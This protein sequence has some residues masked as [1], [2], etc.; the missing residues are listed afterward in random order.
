L[1]FSDYVART[2]NLAYLREAKARQRSAIR[3]S[4]IRPSRADPS[5]R[6]ISPTPPTNSNTTATTTATT[7]DTTTTTESNTEDDNKVHSPS[8]VEREILSGRVVINRK[9][10][11]RSDSSY[12]STSGDYGT[13]GSTCATYFGGNGRGVMH[14]IEVENTNVTAFCSQTIRVESTPRVL[15][16]HPTDL[17]KEIL[18]VIPRD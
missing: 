15:F 7:T 6:P 17:E 5:R 9:E 12:E 13:S 4:R 16:N 3:A 8:V 1:D 18:Q 11:K 10:D 14:H 2:S